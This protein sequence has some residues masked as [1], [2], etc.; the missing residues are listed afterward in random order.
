VSIT[1]E[2]EGA[3]IY[4]TTDGTTP[5]PR[6]AN[7]YTG[8]FEI[9]DTTTVKAIAVKDDERTDL[10]SATIVKKEIVLAT[11]VITP[12]D[13]TEFYKDS[14]TVTI[15]CATEGASIYYVVCDT[16]NVTN[17][18]PSDRN[19]YTGP[20]TVSA[21]K[22]VRAFSMFGSKTSDIVSATLIKRELTLPV[23][24]DAPELAFTT[25]GDAPW[26]P[27]LN[28][29][30]K[31]GGSFAQSGSLSWSIE[32][33]SPSETWMETTVA[34]AGTYSFWWKVDCEDDPFGCT[35]DRF[36]VYTNGVEAARID[37]KT[38]WAKMEF[39]FTDSGTHTV[40]WRFC[41]DD[42]DDE[43]L[44]DLAWVD[45]VVWT[46]AS[47]D[48]TIDVG[49]GKNVVVPA[50]WIDK[51]DSL[52]AAA[53]G[54]KAAALLRPAA[55]GRKVWECFMLG[56]DPTKADDDF[57]ITRFWMEGGE[58]KFEFSHSTDGAGNSFAPRIKTKGKAKLSDGWRDVPAGGDPSFRFF[59]V[60][61]MLP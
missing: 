31:V 35:W 33:D 12:A 27:V 28:G 47:V 39:T 45:G 46:P 26:T 60:E 40:R 38:E 15:S 14:C 11:P 25:G 53:G 56:V 41:K 21:T 54:D 7:L 3:S 20:F 51:Y 58:P 13:G 4:Y 1:C 24:V 10:V 55:N 18:R 57:K 49:D 2:T 19:L 29:S 30:A 34:G 17:P 44:T 61:V 43:K 37:G 22:M 52:V 8:P 16:N 6:P 50:S 48:I 59:T 42:W 36:E 5:R 32:D 9:A 23:A